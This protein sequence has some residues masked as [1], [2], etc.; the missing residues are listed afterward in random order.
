MKYIFLMVGF[1]FFNNSIK[2][3]DVIYNIDEAIIESNTIE[4]TNQQIKCK[5]NEHLDGPKRDILFTDV[6]S[7]IYGDNSRK[8]IDNTNLSEDI[9]K[10]I[11]SQQEATSIS[12]NN[13]I[14][15]QTNNKENSGDYIMFGIGYGNSYGGLGG[16]FQYRDAKNQ[17]L[18]IH[19]GI[20]YFPYAEYLS[21]IGLKYF[22]YKDL[23]LNFQWVRTGWE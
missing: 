18:G 20:G 23:Y 17:R 9:Q 10:T 1:I 12:E 4:S 5:N 11:S 13:T 6:F 3:Q 14:I 2:A 7:N 8:L 21:S 19:I 16:R 22:L 15:E